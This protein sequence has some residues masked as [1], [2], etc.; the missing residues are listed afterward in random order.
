VFWF[1]KLV[2][3]YKNPERKFRVFFDQLNRLEIALDAHDAFILIDVLLE[4]NQRQR[5]IQSSSMCRADSSPTAS[6]TVEG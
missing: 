4:R 1:L 3:E 2:K 6:V 5:A